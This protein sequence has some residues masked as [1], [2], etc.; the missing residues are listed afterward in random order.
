MLS[1]TFTSDLGFHRNAL[2]KKLFFFVWINMF[3][4]FLCLAIVFVP[5]GP[6]MQ[7]SLH[8][9]LPFMLPGW[10]WR[11]GFISV[12]EMFMTPILVSSGINFLIDTFVPMLTVQAR[13]TSAHLFPPLPPPSRSAN[14]ARL[15]ATLA[16]A[17]THAH[18]G[19]EG[20]AADSHPR[21]GLNTCAPRPRRTCG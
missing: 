16:Q 12:D 6:D 11:V 3:F 13:V 7:A 8:G 18:Q 19:R 9:I 1:N 4:W 15:T 20:R 10:G 5:F 14:G 2:T 21:T 17:S